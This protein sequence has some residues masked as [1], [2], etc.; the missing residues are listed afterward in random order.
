[1]LRPLAVLSVVSLALGGCQ[2]VSQRPTEPERIF[3]VLPDPLPAGK[4][5][6]ASFAALPPAGKNGT[7]VIQVRNRNPDGLVSDRQLSA[8]LNAIIKRSKASGGPSYA[9]IEKPCIPSL[10]LQKELKTKEPVCYAP[11][12]GGSV[13]PQPR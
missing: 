10:E 7:R 1:M 5:P 2:L 4:G 9:L 8:E 12:E 13:A 6:K 3:T 11:E